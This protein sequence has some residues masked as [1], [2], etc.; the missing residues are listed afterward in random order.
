M[1]VISY[2]NTKLENEDTKKLLII[3]KYFGY[4][5]IKKSFKNIE[6]YKSQNE[7]VSMFFKNNNINH[8]DNITFY[9]KPENDN[10]IYF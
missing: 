2:D 5:N 4:C 10:K 1:H 6:I 9:F 7:Y 3:L 8:I